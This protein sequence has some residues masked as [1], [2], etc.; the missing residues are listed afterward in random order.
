VSSPTSNVSD[1]E[2]VA[3]E[4]NK[5]IHY[6]IKDDENEAYINLTIKMI[7]LQHITVIKLT[8]IVVIVSRNLLFIKPYK[9]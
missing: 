8:I 2:K 3:I 4:R 7:S 5:S 6:C 1:N 9:Y